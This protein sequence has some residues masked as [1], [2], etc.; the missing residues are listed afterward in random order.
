M[1]ESEWVLVTMKGKR[2]EGVA[3]RRPLSDGTFAEHLCGETYK[4][5][6]T[7]AQEM[8]LAEALAQPLAPA[9]ID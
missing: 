3:F 6:L 9:D 7:T 4:V 2:G 8:E 5:R 1:A